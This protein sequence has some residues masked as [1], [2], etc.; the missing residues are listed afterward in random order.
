LYDDEK[1]TVSFIRVPYD[2]RTAQMRILR[3]GL[4]D[5]LATRLREGR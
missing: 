4:P 1:A 3:A 2:V 5:R